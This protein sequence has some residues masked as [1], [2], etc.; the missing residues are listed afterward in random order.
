MAR[1]KQ[2]LKDVFRGMKGWEK[3]YLKKSIQ[4]GHLEGLDG[5]KFKRVKDKEA[6]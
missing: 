6:L 3:A 4:Y 5:K 2:N 1:R